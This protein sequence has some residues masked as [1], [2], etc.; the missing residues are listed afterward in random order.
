MEE[1]EKARQVLSSYFETYSE[2][3]KKHRVLKNI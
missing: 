1:E 3:R 2:G